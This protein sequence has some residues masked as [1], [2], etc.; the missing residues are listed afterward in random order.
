M[1]LRTTNLS[2]L[3]LLTLALSAPALA[4][5]MSAE[6]TTQSNIDTSITGPVT[7]E[8]KLPARFAPATALTRQSSSL[9]LD[10]YD[11]QLGVTTFRWNRASIRAPSFRGVDSEARS[12]HAATHYLEQM[13]G[14]G[15]A[16]KKQDER[17]VL[18]SLHDM[19]RGPIIAKFAQEFSGVEVFNREINVLMD[20][21][22]DMVAA[23]GYFANINQSHK[24]TP[25]LR[26]FGSQESAFSAALS[27]LS[28]E[29]V[30]AS[31]LGMEKR[32]KFDVAALATD[33]D[34]ELRGLSRAKRVYFPGVSELHPAHYVEIG[35]V[36]PSSGQELL[37]SYV[38][39][40]D[41]D[42]LFRRNLVENEA[43][44]YTVFGRDA[45]KTLLQ[46]PHGDVIPKVGEGPDPSDIVDM[47]VISIDS[48]QSL[49]T[50]DPWIPGPTSVLEGN[51]VI[52]YGDITGGDGKD[53][54][55]ISPLVTAPGV[56]DYAYDPV[57]GATKDNYKAAVVNLFYMNNFLH[58]WWYDHGFDEQ[59]YNAQFS[60]YDRGGVGG[61]PLVVQGQDSSGFNNAN[62]YTPADGASPRMQQYLFFSKEA[63]Y[64]DDWGLTI[65]SHPEIG[66]MPF[67]RP[68]MFGPQVYP[69]LS[70]NIVRGSDTVTSDG[71]TDDDACQTLVNVEDVAGNIL[72]VPTST[73]P[74]CD[75]VTQSANAL[76]AGAIGMVVV[77]AD[78]EYVLFGDVE[79]DV[80][81]T[82]GVSAGDIASV[83][84][85]LDASEVVSADL[86]SN[87]ALKDSTFDNGII[88][89]EWGHYIQ[90]RLVGNAAG[91]VNFQGRAMG[92]GWSDFHALMFMLRE[93]HSLIEGNS[94]FESGYTVSTH[95]A[96][97]TNSV[98]RA[99]YTVDMATNPLTFTH[100]QDGAQPDGLS[101]T[102]NGSPHAAGEMWAAVLWD[103]YVRL[104]NT[105][106]FDEAESRMA[107][108][109][110]AGYKMTPI[111]PTY[112]EARDAILA[113]MYANERDDYVMALEAFARRGM[114]L[115]AVSPARGAYPL[116]GVTESYL[117]QLSTYETTN[118]ELEKDFDGLDAGFCSR[119]GVLD[120]GET[121]TISF[122]VSNAGS[123]FLATVRAQAVVTSNHDVTIEN[124]GLVEFSN[125]DLF[126]TVSSPELKV[127]LNSAGTADTLTM[128]L[129]FLEVE[130]GDDTVEPAPIQ[131]STVVNYDFAP[132]PLVGDQAVEDMED[133]SFFATFEEQVL[134]E[135]SSP[136]EGTQRVD[137]VNVGFFQQF[138]PEPL[139]SRIM[140]LLNNPYP[141]DV[142]AETIEI[143]VGEGDDF[144]ISF[145]HYYW[146]EADWDGGVVE[147]SIDGG[148]WQDASEAGG[149]FAIG[150][151]STLLAFNQSALSGRPAFTGR[152]DPDGFEGVRET[153]SFGS[154]LNGSTV[155]FRFRIASDYSVSEY[156][157]WID[158]VTV[159]NIASPMLFE[160]VA[161]D[162][163][164]C[165]NSLPRVALDRTGDSTQEGGSVQ[166]SAT[167]TDRN[168]TDV[169]SYSWAQ[170][171][172]PEAEL[173]GADTLDVTITSPR[174]K[175]TE[176]LVFDFTVDDGSGGVVTERFSLE[177][178]NIPPE[179]VLSGS[180]GALD[181]GS[182]AAIAVEVTNGA[183]DDEYTYEWIQVSGTSATLTGQST[184]NLAVTLPRIA[185]ETE[186]L[187][188][189]VSV[190]DG[191]DA[192]VEEYTLTAVNIAPTTSVSLDQ[193][194]VQEGEPVAATV[195]VTNSAVGENYTY[196]WTQI[197]GTPASISGRTLTSATITTPK[198][199]ATETLRFDVIVSDGVV[200]VST[201]FSITVQNKPSSGGSLDW[202]ILG[203]V[204]LL[205]LRRRRF[206]TK[207]A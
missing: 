91:L 53:D 183:E 56:W 79:P 1:Y 189:N 101:P 20:R 131:L 84:A 133:R 134:Y 43:Y 22:L 177:V 132:R 46:G 23:S 17:A 196:S 206:L 44:D 24:S 27:D 143:A 122:D 93:S 102:S 74:D 112:T 129:Q 138:T 47:T 202:L 195:T 188:F 96:N 25:K 136:A 123:E 167:A 71:G 207:V 55:D 72:L 182:A 160:T 87:G 185:Q 168:T 33:R 18:T 21:D 140:L 116:S 199:S 12:R 30:N 174:V 2:F 82:V 200:N 5:V 35:L 36:H 105:Y 141:T 179:L 62:M 157:W 26:L 164:V 125:L 153:I 83:E 151:P 117:S 97:F 77:V 187:V 166:V 14:V 147:V 115:G 120:V 135:E 32:G 114:G 150:Y 80:V 145:W 156:G 198:V 59:S 124:D 180:E 15:S 60:N 6:P 10:R 149:E 161:G 181:E 78:N 29:R 100:I 163:V 85:L 34:L 37:Y 64:G 70:A 88:A 119:D 192:T 48:H 127:V 51:N 103:V 11:D 152:S 49:S 148:D 170:V 61:D 57:N 118:F 130:T 65:T 175:D 52:A 172:G 66:L 38:I 108:Y 178:T 154:A 113:A 39:G 128:E 8:L 193:S 190:S 99:P 90:N 4:V 68:A 158:N 67:T 111:A 107:D 89:H 126:E 197:S 31:M 137:T 191:V 7:Q 171:S 176:I 194:S 205:G 110:V 169:L 19:G 159:T 81:P 109:L 203:L 28:G 184:P 45:D 69:T 92:E 86:F 165:D 121:G 75:Y 186:T 173:T 162:S 201:P 144:S 204:T 98:R 54:T 40:R 58:N 139:G 50:R 9:P 16:A 13:T 95:V 3:S 41:G 42:V 94:N 146:I 142:A 63:D 73:V 76:A 104:L 106:D 155:R